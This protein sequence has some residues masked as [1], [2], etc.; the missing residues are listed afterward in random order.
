MITGVQIKQIAEVI[1]QIFSKISFKDLPQKIGS[2]MDEG[3][4]DNKC[5]ELPQNEENSLRTDIPNNLHIE[6]GS[7][8]SQVMLIHHNK[9]ATSTSPNCK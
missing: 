9:D 4:N 5:E 3:K 1:S 6:D 8:N 2:A 7:S